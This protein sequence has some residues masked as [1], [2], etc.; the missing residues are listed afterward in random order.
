MSK[1][2]EMRIETERLVIRPY[3][4]EEV[5]EC[6]QLMQ[7]KELFTYLDMEV[8]TYEEYQSL[9][10]WLISCYETEMT[11][12][13]KYSFNITLKEC[14]TH[15]GWC[16]LGGVEFD[17]D[18][19]EVFYLIGKDYWGKGYA[20]EAASA[21]L[22]FGFNEM[23]LNEIIGLCKPDNLASRKVL[24]GIGLA[25]RCIMSGLP[26]EFDFYNGEPCF[27]L[28]REVFLNRKKAQ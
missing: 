6:F 12:D 28:T 15:I 8:M 1:I 20:K 4:K 10:Y 7:D 25:Y 21:M 23:Q 14:G 18:Q 16:G 17:H 5:D 11:Q 27:S 22:D 13:F 19:K 26:E 9:F 2:N 3:E 24:E